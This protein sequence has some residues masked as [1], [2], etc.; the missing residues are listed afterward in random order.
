MSTKISRRK[1]VTRLGIAGAAAGGSWVLSGRPVRA[2]P[3]PGTDPVPDPNHITPTRGGFQVLPT[4]AD[5]HANL[6]GKRRDPLPPDHAQAIET[7]KPKTAAT[8][9]QPKAQEK[10][11]FTAWGKEVSGL[12]AGLGFK[13]D[14]KRAYTHAPPHGWHTCAH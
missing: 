5:D 2:T 6:L 3:G 9:L 1:F 10:E 13:A 14:E 7:E 12:Q 11:P 4:G 8:E